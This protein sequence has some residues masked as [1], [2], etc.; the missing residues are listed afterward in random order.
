MPAPAQLDRARRGAEPDVAGRLRRAERLGDGRADRLAELVP[1]RV[2]VPRRLPVAEPV[3]PARDVAAAAR[4]EE[5]L[6]ARP[7]ARTA[8]R[9]GPGKSAFQSSVCPPISVGWQAKLATTA[10]GVPSARSTAITPT[11]SSTGRSG[12][13]R[14]TVMPGRAAGPRPDARRRERA[15]GRVDDTGDRLRQQL[16]VAGEGGSI[17]QPGDAAAAREARRAV[18]VGRVHQHGVRR[19]PGQRLRRARAPRPSGRRPRRRGRVATIAIVVLAVVEHER[20]RDE[21]V[22][23]SLREARAQGPAAVGQPARRV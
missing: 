8:S 23:D 12:T 7:R 2:G 9:S 22:V 5:A 11:V 20:L 19:D 4:E 1:P 13:T 16:D 21:G 10:R 14:L 18:V 17:A 15:P 3:V 6:G